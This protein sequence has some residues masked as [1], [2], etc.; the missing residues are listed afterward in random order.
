MASATDLYSIGI[1]EKG[2]V[3]SA[4]SEASGYPKERLLDWNPDVYWKPTSTADQTI[5]ID[6]GSAQQVQRFFLWIHNYTTNHTSGSSAVRVSYSSS[7]GSGYTVW[8]TRLFSAGFGLGTPIFAGSSSL[9]A[10]TYRYWKIEF[11]NM[12]T[13]IEVS[14]IFLCKKHSLIAD[15]WPENDAIVYANRQVSGPGGRLFVSG[16]NRNAFREFSRTFYMTQTSHWTAFSDA[17]D[18]C[19]GTLFPMVMIETD[20][21]GTKY[22]R[23]VDQGVDW[24]KFGHQLYRPTVRFREIPHIYPGEAL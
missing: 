23:F 24:N 2:S 9:T 21:I 4:T 20:G 6:L 16:V 13:T 19:R 7:V 17:W 8:E 22:C 18:A 14:G 5:V 3:Y 10:Q 15:E 1:M 11:I 12:A